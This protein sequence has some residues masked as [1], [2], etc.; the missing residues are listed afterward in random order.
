MHHPSPAAVAVAGP[1]NS[2]HLAKIQVAG[3][4]ADVLPHPTLPCYLLVTPACIL[5][6]SG[7]NSFP[8]DGCGDVQ[9]HIKPHPALPCHLL[10]TPPFYPPPPHSHSLP[11]DGCGDVRWHVK[12]LAALPRHRAGRGAAQDDPHRHHGAGRGGVP[13]LHGWVPLLNWVGGAA[14][15]VVLLVRSHHGAGGDE[16]YLNFMG[17]W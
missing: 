11:A 1:W 15:R 9:R 10:I 14:I 8:A 17:W 5:P 4:R 12:P 16:A 7:A 3:G 2:W 6:S 13:Q